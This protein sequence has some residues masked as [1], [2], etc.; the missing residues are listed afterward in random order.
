MKFPPFLVVTVI[1]GFGVPAALAITKPGI[2]LPVPAFTNS[3]AGVV[4]VSAK[5][6]ANDGFTSVSF[7]YGLKTASELTTPVSTVA[8]GTVDGL[9]TITVSGLVGGAEY[10]FKA[11]A[12]N[13]GGMVTSADFPVKVDAYAPTLTAKSP[14]LLHATTATLNA[15][16]RGNGKAGYKVL[17][18][19]GTAADQLTTAVTAL[20]VAKDAPANTLVSTTLVGLEREKTYFYRIVLNDPNGQ[21]VLSLPESGVLPGSGNPFTFKTQNTAPIAKPIKVILENP[22]ARL[23]PVPG[24]DKADAD[25]DIVK[26]TRVSQ[27]PLHGT[28]SIQGSAIIYT[29]GQNF[30][31]SDTFSYLLED[32]HGG[33]ASGLVT[34]ESP[35]VAVRGQRNAL[36]R[37]ADGKNVGL[38]RL[39]VEA[40][41]AFSGK[42]QIDGK[43]YKVHG[44]FDA[45]GR[46]VGT[47]EGDDGSLPVALTVSLGETN[48]TLS[49]NFGSQWSASTSLAGISMEKQEELAGRYTLE[50]PAATAAS[51]KTTG[52]DPTSVDAVTGDA[53]TTTSTAVQG[54]GWAVIKL[55]EFGSARIKGKTSDG[56]SF[57]ADAVLGGTTAA[58]TLNFYAKQ[59]R[60]AL[61]G[62]L[63]LGSKVTGE[64]QVVGRGAAAALA[65]NGA[66][67][68]PPDGEQRALMTATTEG[69]FGTVTISG[70]GA[71][72]VAHA[73]R[74]GKNNDVQVVDPT[75]DGFNLKFNEA[76]GQFRGKIRPADG[77]DDRE[78]ISGVFLQ[79]QALG[80]GVSV[81][82]GAVRRVEISVTA[83]AAST[84]TTTT[85]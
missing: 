5:V 33:T 76:T 72:S 79:N 43:S 40:S 81:G 6:T 22:S 24:V 35:R 29:P 64:V 74:F 80:R 63:T 19:Y 23:I 56:E 9:V 82:G 32:G 75:E 18:V 3:A 65:V 70:T 4:K 1:L 39:L 78:K 42:V 60:S 53:T 8:A 41:G 57:S 73:V 85:P 62:A 15:A 50:L 30:A 67:Y 13:T 68:L 54:A 66:P 83:K 84:A 36:I 2:S 14:S 17:F 48:S 44:A 38:V 59:E 25:G 26:L 20:E 52:T 12:S 71:G 69:K 7:D 61:T 77:S 37:D 55:N 27:K 31:G 11:K 58:P 34:I 28:A 16:V 47:A 51:T 49:G 46:F 45:S 10:Q 21:S